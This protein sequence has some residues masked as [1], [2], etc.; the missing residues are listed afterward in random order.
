MKVRFYDIEW[1]T[2]GEEVDLPNELVIDFPEIG[3][4]GEPEHSEDVDDDIVDTFADRLT[5]LTDWCVRDFRWALVMEQ[6]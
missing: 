4:H 5:D 6:S 3:E 2:D 1:D